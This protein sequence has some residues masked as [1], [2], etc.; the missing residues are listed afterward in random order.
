M[1]YLWRNCHENIHFLTQ[2]KNA[3]KEAE[4][5]KSKQMKEEADI[6]FRKQNDVDF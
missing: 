3:T 1:S 2:K 5:A 4:S 6:F